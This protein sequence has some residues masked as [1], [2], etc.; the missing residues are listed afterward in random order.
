MRTP[1]VKIEG[2]T[3]GLNHPT[4]F[5]ADVAANHDGDLEKAKELIW[6]VAEAG[7]DAAKFQNFQAETIV[8]DHGFKSM[9]GQVSH[10][11]KW[12]KSV[13]ETYQDAELPLEWTETL[14]ETCDKAGVH[15]FTSPYSPDLIEAVKPYVAAWKV[16]SGEV[17]WHDAIKTMG[18]TG[19]TVIL[20]TGATTMDEVRMAVKA[21]QSATDQVILMQCNTNYT[22]NNDEPREEALARMSCINLR[23]LD[24]YGKEFPNV[25]LGLSDH[26]L[27]HTTVVGSVAL[28]NARAVEKHFTLD[29][30]AEGPDH[31][32]SMNPATWRE[33]VDATRAVE[34]DLKEDMTYDQRIELIRP[35]VDMDELEAALGDGIKRIED[36]E[37][38]TCVVQRRA[39][40]TKT[41]LPAGHI[42]TEA[43]LFPLRPAIKGGLQPY[44]TDLAVGKK[45]GKDYAKG[46]MLRP[47]D[48][49]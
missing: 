36:N 9:G 43:D 14:K 23:V 12:K 40:C 31:P 11:S 47:S 35:Y 1:E 26:T 32:F 42:L 18:E 34:K 30:N 37:K 38:D 22:A 17:T 27:G 44:Q 49:K 24:L 6:A 4:Y 16:G 46:E 3:V 13:F 5:I 25:V 8:S 41:D 19:K 10:Q 29:N 33:M 45:L 20:A 48:I 39:I 21:A 2:Q 28:F 7:G 15:Y